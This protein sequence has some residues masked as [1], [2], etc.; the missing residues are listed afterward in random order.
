MYARVHAL[1]D[2]GNKSVVDSSDD[3]LIVVIPYLIFWLFNGI[4]TL[5]NLVTLDYNP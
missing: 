4:I 5:L 3:K 2:V 1:S